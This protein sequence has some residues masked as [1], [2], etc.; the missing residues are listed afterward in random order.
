MVLAP[1]RGGSI[2]ALGLIIGVIGLLV[3]LHG[4]VEV[5]IIVVMFGLIAIGAVMLVLAN[6]HR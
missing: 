3:G 4:A 6:R 5:A 1:S 2:M